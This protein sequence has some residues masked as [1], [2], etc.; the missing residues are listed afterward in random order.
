VGLDDFHELELRAAA[1]EVLAGAVVFGIF[2]DSAKSMSTGDNA[3]Q[4]RVLLAK[5]TSVAG[6]WAGNARFN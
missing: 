6:L 2:P 4:I 3:S 5:S 1:V